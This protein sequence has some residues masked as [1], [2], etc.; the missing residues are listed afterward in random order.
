MIRIQGGN[1]V[2]I[3]QRLQEIKSTLGKDTT[4]VCVS[5]TKPAMLIQEAYDSGQRDFGENKVQEFL[6]KYDQLPKDIRWHFVGTLQKNKVKYIVDKIFLL[7][8]LDSLELA[9]EVEKW[10]SKKEV[11]LNCLVQINLGREEAKHG[12]YPEEITSFLEQCRA[13]HHICIRG[14]MIVIPK[15][16][17]IQCKCFFKQAKE[18]FS[19]AV[20]LKQ[21]NISLEILSMGMSNDYEWAIEEG[22]NMVRVGQKI[23]GEREYNVKI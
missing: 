20:S 21:D 22:S 16:E 12:I 3:S 4:L 9:R 15:G 1:D 2:S 7:Q 14:I 23:F 18:I 10:C 19:K 13:F 6:K 5:K 11:M 8:S 17:E